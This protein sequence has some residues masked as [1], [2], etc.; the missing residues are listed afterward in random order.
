[1]SAE[2]PMDKPAGGGPNWRGWLRGT[3]WGIL[4]ISLSIIVGFILAMPWWRGRDFLA[5]GIASAVLMAAC[6][7]LLRQ[8]KAAN[9]RQLLI[10]LLAAEFTIGVIVSFHWDFLVYFSR[11]IAIPWLAGI[12]AGHIACRSRDAT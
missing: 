8:R 7:F 12:G 10:A 5:W 6:G 11:F 4:G 3:A 9:T 2:K 1:M